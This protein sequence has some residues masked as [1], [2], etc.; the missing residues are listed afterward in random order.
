M[1]TSGISCRMESDSQFT[2]DLS[3]IIEQYRSGDWG[4]VDEED[5]Q[6]NIDTC[7]SK[8]GSLMGCYKTFDQTRIWIITSGYGNQRYGRDYCY[9]TVLFPEEY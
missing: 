5:W 6:T 2:D 8:G 9:T 4:Q 7:K 1:F 3:K